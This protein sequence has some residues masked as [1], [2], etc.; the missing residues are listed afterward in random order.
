MTLCIMTYIIG[1]SYD[2]LKMAH[3]HCIIL[4]LMQNLMRNYK[5]TSNT[6]KL[7]DILQSQVLFRSV[8]DMNDDLK[9]AHS[10][11]IILPL[12]QNLMR[13]YKKTSDKHT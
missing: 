13:N 10:H 4:P 6:L 3:S 8:K 11:C 9:M 1:M 5:K 7:R 2:D 12:M